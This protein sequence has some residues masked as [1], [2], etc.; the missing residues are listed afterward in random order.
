MQY[1][2]YSKFIIV[3]GYNSKDHTMES[4]RDFFI[5]KVL[6]SNFDIT[7]EELETETL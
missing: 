2:K 4:I 3:A 7:I 5:D 1:D 6:S